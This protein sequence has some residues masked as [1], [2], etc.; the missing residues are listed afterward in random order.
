MDNEGLGC[1]AHWSLFILYMFY[2]P[3]MIIRRHWSRGHHSKI[4]KPV[5]VSV[6][7]IDDDVA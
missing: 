6:T 1:E 2:L 3:F 5:L 7:C 4:A